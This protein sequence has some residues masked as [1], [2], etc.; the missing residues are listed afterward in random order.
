MAVTDDVQALLQDPNVLQRVIAYVAARG[1]SAPVYFIANRCLKCRT[2]TAR[3]Y[4]REA[5]AGT[6]LVAK[7]EVALLHEVGG[8][9]TT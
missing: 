5:S 6:F 2:A 4:L 8:C 9:R 1:G 7:D 3:A